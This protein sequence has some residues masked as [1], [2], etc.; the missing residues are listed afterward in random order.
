MLL[1]II[2]VE[3]F[4]NTI[5]T[6]ALPET[7]FYVVFTIYNCLLLLLL[8]L[9][10]LYSLLLGLDRFFSF[11]ILHTVSRTSW[12]GDQAVARPL[13]THRTTQTQNKRTQYTHPYLEWDSNQGFQRS[14][15]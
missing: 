1:E 9:L 3:Y 4:K 14:S 2:S 11:M 15:E 13:H 7:V 12:S 5:M 6:Y 10:W 8:L